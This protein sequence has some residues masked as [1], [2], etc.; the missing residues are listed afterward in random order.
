[1]KRCTIHRSL[2]CFVLSVVAGPGALRAQHLDVL[3]QQQNGTL[4]T[5]SANF[6][7]TTWTIGRRVFSGEFDAD[8][9]VNSPGYNA[10]AAGSSS[11]PAGA[12]ALLPNRALSWDFLPMTIAPQVSNL[13]YWN[14][15]ESDGSPGITPGDVQ[16]GPLPGPGYTLALFDQSGGSFAVNGGPGFVPGGTIDSTATDGS[17]HRHR[18]YFLQDGDGN[19]STLP[20]DGIYLFALRFRMV[21][22]VESKP[23][24]MVFGTPGSSVA[25]LD[26]AAVPWAELQLNLP[27]DYN[28]N[29]VVDG[30]DYVLWRDM[31]GQSGAGLAADGD[32]NQQVNQAD[33]LVWRQNFG[34]RSQLIVG[35]GPA[36]G[37]GWVAG[38][39]IPEPSS[40][41][42]F[43]VAVAMIGAANRGRK[44]GYTR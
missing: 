1:M 44:K 4:V 38:A 13:F 20:A 25:A 39:T 27:G 23:V 28:G 33:Y 21:G 16:F 42:V 43:L 40:A 7:T 12:Q 8:F 17:L 35:N 5:G 31:N 36:S 34:A 2:A 29:G 32:G 18:F 15:L 22:L 6:D 3:V 9:A 41:H 30:A 10:L 19:P 37:S 11:M 24:L 26:V 14:G